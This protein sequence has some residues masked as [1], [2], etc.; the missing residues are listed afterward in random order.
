MSHA[1]PGKALARDLFVA[2]VAAWG[3]G[4]LYGAL[5]RV[6]STWDE[7]AAWER[8]VLRWFHSWTLPS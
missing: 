8:N 4:I 3:V 6:T 1:S 5:I 7:G 2:Y